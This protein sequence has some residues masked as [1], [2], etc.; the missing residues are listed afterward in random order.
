MDSVK[1][2][3]TISKWTS[4]LRNS[5]AL[6]KN[7][8]D[9]YFSDIKLL[10][11]FLGDYKAEEI[12]FKHLKGIEKTD[13]RAWFLYRK[14]RGESTR[15][16][17]RGLSALKSFL[18]YLIENEIIKTS[19][20]LGMRPPKIEKTLPRPLTIEQINNILS[21][22]DVI[23]QK[24]WIVKRDRTLLV[25]IYS[26]GLRISEALSLNKDDILSSSDFIKIIGKGDKV[27]MVPLIAHVKKIILNYLESREFRDSEAL[28]V[29]KA[30]E[31]L[32]SS[33]VQKLMQRVRKMLGLS[34]K[35]TLH[36]FRHSCATHLMENSGDI[37]SIQE[38]LGHSS[39]SSTQIY[40]DVAQKYVSEIYAKCHPLSKAKKQ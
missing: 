29:N 25:L 12:S 11:R 10:V 20:V 37:R 33:A 6:S 30:G 36:A 14:N 38:L 21:V 2:E 5:R 16:V 4:C 24:D 32:S 17:S 15:T 34:E 22:I 9:S 39:I 27:R 7:T 18:K 28:F 35:V 31:R 8:V 19:D 3:D 26:V 23:K 1:L 40:A 13:V